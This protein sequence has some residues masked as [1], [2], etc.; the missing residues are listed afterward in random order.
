MVAVVTESFA[1]GA[2]FN[3]SMRSSHEYLDAPTTQTRGTAIN[4]AFN[5]IVSDYPFEDLQRN[6]S[7]L[8]RLEPVE[9]MSAYRSSLVSDRRSVLLVTS[10]SSAAVNGS[11]VDFTY[12]NIDA[13]NAGQNFYGGLF[14]PLSWMCAFFLTYD[15]DTV[16]NADDA[17]KRVDSWTLFQQPIEYCLSEKVTDHCR[18]QWSTT[19][20]IV[21][22]CA[23]I[24]KLLAMIAALWTLPQNTLAMVGDAAA[25]F[26]SHPDPTTEGA[27]LLSRDNIVKERKGKAWSPTTKPGARNF[28]KSQ[29]SHH[30]QHHQRW[31]KAPSV[32]RWA[33]CVL[34]CVATWGTAIGLL[35]EGLSTLKLAGL[36]IDMSSLWK[37]GFGA[38]NTRA[39]VRLN[40]TIWAPENSTLNFVLLANLPQLVL[41][42]LYFTVNGLLTT[43]CIS[44]EWLGFG[45]QRTGLRV[46]FPVK[47]SAQRSSYFLS[48]PYKYAIPML[49]GAG[50]L[51][52]LISQSIFLVKIDVFDAWGVHQR[53][54]DITTAGYSG[55][56]LIFVLILG[57]VMLAALVAVG[58]QKLPT[59]SGMPNAGSCSVVISAACHAP[60]EEIDDIALKPLMWGAVPD[61]GMLEHHGGLAGHCCLSSQQVT[62]PKAGK[63]YS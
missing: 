54:K 49:I 28:A 1:Q 11:L 62:K 48:L 19:I 60:V 31:Y 53:A 6:V 14:D 38:V 51:H 63:S 3:N 10:N 34:F 56:A 32:K 39:L 9:C 45:V 25:S 15:S 16:C 20:M 27:C 4:V 36:S 61:R 58:F 47:G 5:D 18:L 7:S 37:M 57:A 43:M 30:S 41:S 12:R 44:D 52:W 33:L 46:S 29:Q 42:L 17:I 59:E 35:G 22:I 24:M 21:V 23:N 13:T 40:H 26:L 2:Y 50:L 8:Q 55:I